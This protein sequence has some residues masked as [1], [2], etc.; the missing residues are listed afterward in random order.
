MEARFIVNRQCRE[1]DPAAFARV[2]YAKTRMVYVVLALLYWGIMLYYLWRGFD[3]F[4]GIFILTAVLFTLLTIFYPQY[5]GWRIRRAANKR[6]KITGVLYKFSDDGFE[7]TTDLDNGTAKYDTLMKIVED[8]NYF[9]LFVQKYSA[10]IVPK[11]D[12][13]SGDPAEFSAFI[14]EKT[15][16]EVKRTYK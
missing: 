16:L 12:F 2:A 3:W 5:M 11:C 7:V 4:D 10:Y 1:E 13:S 14:A 6:A 15:G 8:K 9:F